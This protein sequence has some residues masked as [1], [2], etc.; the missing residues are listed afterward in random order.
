MRR[1]G[2]LLIVA[3]SVLGLAASPPPPTAAPARQVLYAG[4]GSAPRVIRLQYSGSA[5]GTILTS[6]TTIQNNN[7]LAVID[8]S[9]DD[10]R[11]F[12]QIAT[13]ADPAAANGG[14]ICC[15][16][17][18]E[19]P[20][21]VGAMPAGTVLF[22]DTAG[23]GAPAGVRHVTENLWDSTDHGVTWRFLSTFATAPN[24]FNT[25]EPSLEV[26]AD[27]QLVAFYSDETDKTHHDQKLV[28]VRSADGVHWSD[29]KSTVASND[30]Y[31]RPG[32][33]NVIRLP[34]GMYFMTYEVCNN[35]LVHLCATYFRESID[36]W[37]YGDPTDLGAVVRTTTGGYARHT[38]YVA[39]SPGPGPNGTIL[40]IA[41]M[42]VNA[43]GSIAPED[44]KAILANDNLGSG[45]WYEIPSPI[46]IDGVNNTGCKNFSSSILPSTDGKSVLEVATDLNNNV[47]QT[48]YAT[49]PLTE[50]T[51]A[52]NS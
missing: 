19:L 7:G 49:S 47:C 52:P 43:D 29:Y 26:E 41:E 33:A 9:T 37:D 12:H 15:S 44:G 30:W 21:P 42:I 31:V 40:I 20:S 48:Y 5:N 32:M 22:A 28:Q 50:P 35:D 46:A 11:T 27:G 1:V 8:S 3:L 18:F 38:P 2:V 16:T 51:A 4:G 13:I 24:P 34:D 14:N 10:G 39:W 6:L 36:G 17:L 23:Y 45:A 25:W